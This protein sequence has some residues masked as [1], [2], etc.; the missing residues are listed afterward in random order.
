[1]LTYNL[2]GIPSGLKVTPEAAADIF[3]G[4]IKKWN[5]PALAKEN[6]DAKLPDKDIA[7]VHRSD[8]SGTTKIFVDYLSTV[9]PD[10]KSGPGTGTSVNWPGGLG[11]KGN[12]GISALISST[13]NSV[14]YI[15][16]AFAMQNKLT[17]AAIKN[18]SG[19]FILPSLESTTAAGSGAAGS[20][21]APALEQVVGRLVVRGG[22]VDQRIVGCHRRIDVP[23]LLRQPAVPA[24]THALRRLLQVSPPG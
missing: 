5:D 22:E 17:F 23:L 2:E 8:G 7:S 15:E 10:W 9:S 19:K 16:L 11:A 20:L 18:K 14:G 6:P 24:V 13:P 4:K 12:E 21:V 3:L 1:M